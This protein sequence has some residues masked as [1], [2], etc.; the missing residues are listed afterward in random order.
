MYCTQCGFELPAG[1]AH[2]PSCGKPPASLLAPSA[3]ADRATGT[4]GIKP[5]TYL[6]FAILTTI[7]CCW[8]LGVVALVYAAQV[9]SKY[10]QGDLQTASR[11]SNNA[12]LWCWLSF[13]AIVILG[14]LYLLIVLL[15]VILDA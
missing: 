5:Q 11:Y 4:G 2:C 14:A 13:G 12:K 8:P 9:D 15:V 6:I 7:F 1:A 10:Y 3:S